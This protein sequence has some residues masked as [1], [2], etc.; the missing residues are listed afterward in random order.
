MGRLMGSPTSWGSRRVR[1]QRMMKR[2]DDAD[3]VS[4]VRSL[5]VVAGRRCTSIPLSPC[6]K[7]PIDR[8]PRAD[9]CCGLPL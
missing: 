3:L 4:R 6:R 5:S 7:A 9:V 2:C 1:Q 8:L